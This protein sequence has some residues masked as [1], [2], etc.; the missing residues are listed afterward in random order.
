MANH[1][2]SFDRGEIL[3]GMGA[4]WFV[5]YSYYKKINRNHMNWDRVSTSEVRISIYDNSTKNHKFWLEQVLSMNPLKLNTNKIGLKADQTKA[6]AKE[7]LDKW[8]S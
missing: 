7:L 8:E 2:F 1:D 3:T 4:S 5:S 6:M